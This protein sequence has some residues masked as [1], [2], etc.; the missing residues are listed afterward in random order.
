MGHLGRVDGAEGGV[1]LEVP[2][3]SVLEMPYQVVWIQNGAGLEFSGVLCTC[4][5]LV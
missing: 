2:E 4:V 5:I 3:C 1:N